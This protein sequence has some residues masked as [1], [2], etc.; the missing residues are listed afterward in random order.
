MMGSASA[1]LA[2]VIGW[3]VAHSMSPLLHDY[4]LREH[5]VNGAYLLLPVLREKLSVALESL[6]ATGFCGVNVTVPHKVASFAVAHELDE[7]ALATGAVNL[8]LFRDGRLLGRNTDALGLQASLEESLGPAALRGSS[9]A[10]LGA[11]GAA[12]ATVLACDKMQ[13]ATIRVFNRRAERA[14]FLVTAMRPHIHAELYACAWADW[15][16]AAKGIFLL[17]NTTSGGMKGAEPLDFNL[18]GLPFGACVCDIV[19]NPLKTK[20]LEGARARGHRSV[21]GLGMLMHQAVPA[22]EAFYGVKPRVTPALRA[23]LERALSHVG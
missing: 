8:V 10:I 22:F 23:E 4:W 17:V 5:G 11:G 12:R 7:L 1:R 9:V 6:Q 2:G 20:L 19:Y 16:R 14:E 3:P 15:P 13:A 18:D 21:D